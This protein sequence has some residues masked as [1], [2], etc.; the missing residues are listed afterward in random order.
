MDAGIKKLQLELKVSDVCGKK[1]KDKYKKRC[2][3]SSAKI[4]R[5]GKTIHQIPNLRPAHSGKELRT[6]LLIYPNPVNT[7]L[8][9]QSQ[10]ASNVVSI[11]ILNTLGETLSLPL[12]ENNAT[13]IQEVSV[14]TLP[15]GVYYLSI[16]FEN[17]ERIVK[18]FIKH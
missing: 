14:A 6:P 2:S 9:I 18:R 7:V 11:T 13:L 3:E 10:F 4:V 17:N 5:T 15:A 16:L 12:K 8:K 1:R